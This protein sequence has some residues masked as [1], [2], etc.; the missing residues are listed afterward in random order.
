MKRQME[1][2]A[3]LLVGL[4]LIMLVVLSPLA[5]VWALNTL[6]SLSIDYSVQTWLAALVV[7]VAF[8]IV[9][10]VK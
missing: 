6:F 2:T 1:N 5:L 7:I 4:A 3:F 10:K 9:V 8:K